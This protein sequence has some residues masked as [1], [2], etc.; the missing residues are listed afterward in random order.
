MN[1]NCESIDLNHFT[2]SLAKRNKFCLNKDPITSPVFERAPITRDTRV[3][4]MPCMFG[5][6][7]YTLVKRGLKAKNIFALER[8][9]EV[10]Q[11]LINCRHPERKLLK[12]MQTTECPMYASK[13]VDRAWLT[14]SEKVDIAYFDFFGQPDYMEHGVNVIR[15]IFELQMLKKDAALILTFGKTRCH[16]S[17]KHMNSAQFNKEL[18][19]QYKL[20]HCLATEL[21]VGA[22]LK[23]FDIKDYRLQ[24]Y[25]YIS[26]GGNNRRLQYLTTI[27]TLGK[28]NK[29]NLLTY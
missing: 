15:K 8:D 11:E 21:F 10:H 26:T 12:G 28:F 29:I 23:E 4:C 22:A 9:K 17:T 19:K 6:E 27:L 5:R 1:C 14:F 13:G 24:S 20:T 25:P 18:I 7:A 2:S 3:V 16:S